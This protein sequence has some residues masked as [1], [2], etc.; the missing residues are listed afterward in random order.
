M[1]GFWMPITQGLGV[2]L[3]PPCTE[4]PRIKLEVGDTVLVTRWRKYWLF[5]E[6]VQN[7][8][9]NGHETVPRIK[10]WFPRKCAVE[11]VD[12]EELTPTNSKNEKKINWCWFFCYLVFFCNTQCIFAFIYVLRISSC[13]CDFLNNNDNTSGNTYFYCVTFT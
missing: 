5:G 10:G 12:C 6:K 8:V 11:I 4:E 9:A 7:V 1:S 2:C 3:H 13:F